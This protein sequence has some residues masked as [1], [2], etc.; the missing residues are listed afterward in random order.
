M[1]QGSLMSLLSRKIQ[2]KCLHASVRTRGMT[3]RR[4]QSQ[5]QATKVLALALSIRAHFGPVCDWVCLPRLPTSPPS[6]TF[7]GAAASRNASESHGHAVR[8]PVGAEP[9]VEPR[10]LEPE[11]QSIRARLASVWLP[12]VTGRTPPAGRGSHVWFGRCSTHSAQ[13]LHLRR[14]EI[15]K[16]VTT[17]TWNQ[18]FLGLCQGTRHRGC[19]KIT[20]RAHISKERL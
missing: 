18:H 1:L 16:P 5:E 9:R 6:R 12:R 17:A 20:R 3:R 11:S 7:D 10:G 15:C 4:R 2:M 13:I 14:K 19:R 8:Q